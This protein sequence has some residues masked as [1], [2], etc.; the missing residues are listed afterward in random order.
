MKIRKIEIDNYR[1]LKEVEIY[2]RDILTLV[3]RNNS[4]K[5]NVIKALEFFFDGSASLI[6]DNCFFNN[7]FSVPIKIFITFEELTEWEEEQFK[8]WMKGNELIIGRIVSYN[9]DG[10]FSVANYSVKEVPDPIWLRL[11]EVNGKNI[12][13][14][15]GKKESLMVSGLNFGAKLGGSKPTVAKWKEI[16]EGFLKDNLDKI[17]MSEIRE[18]NPKGYPG[19]LQGSLPEFIHV[20]AISDISVESKVHKTNPF[21][22]IINSV[23]EKISDEKLEALSKQ[24]KDIEKKLNKSGGS[25]RI[26]EIKKVETRLNQ[27]MLEL[28]DCKIEIE[29][30]MPK[31]KEIVAGT[32]IFADDGFRTPIEV[33]GHGLQRSMIFTILRA[34]AEY[35]HTKK[36]KKETGLRSTI[37]AIE[38]PELYLHPQFQRTFA[39]VF[40]EIA[41]GRDQVI[42]STH[43]SL[44][45]DIANFDE[46]CIMRREKKGGIIES[47]CT[48]LSIETLLEDLEARGNQGTEEGIRELYSKVFNP[49][50]N[51]GFF[52]DK[53][54][55]VEGPTE[56]YSLPIYAKCL[57]YN[58]DKS[59]IS[60]AQTHGK[61]Q[62]DRLLRIFNGFHIPTYLIFDG[63]KDHTHPEIVRKS[64]ELLDLVGDPITTSSDIRTK[65]EDQ[66]TMFEFKLEKILESEIDDYSDYI[67]EMPSYI[68]RSKPLR[69]RFISREIL[70][71][72]IDGDD[73]EEL[74]PETISR[75]ISKVKALKWKS[76]VLRKLP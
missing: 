5:S 33:K 31:L 45:V 35:S 19:V 1:S 76:G 66:Y 44:F 74:V 58:F 57:D 32:K 12:S 52:A 59:N 69:Q 11:S 50:I 10:S 51:E 6:D 73:P 56:E 27:L 68:S 42:Y 41:S 4:G 46:I 43:S 30:T 47:K 60:V 20:P 65:V 37:F 22:Q 63:D 14:W 28:M 62:M 38:E 49:V 7:D 15:W 34:Y 71:K 75:I 17:P 54:I 24:L 48:Q 40:R 8:S 21:G 18:K 53:V 72:I 23:V 67:A 29:M 13:E 36:T 25:D 9:E 39:S 64:L 16:I 3:G 26:D 55:I 2:P 70:K 61:G